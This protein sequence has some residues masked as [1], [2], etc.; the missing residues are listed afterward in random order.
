M[1]RSRR[2]TPPGESRPADD[3]VPATGT[4]ETE[5]GASAMNPTEPERTYAP[6]PDPTLDPVLGP[7]RERVAGSPPP[8]VERE[9]GISP[10]L[11]AALGGV[12]GGIIVAGGG[13]WYL[14]SQPFVP[15]TVSAKLDAL[16]QVR[17]QTQ[18]MAG[19]VGALRSRVDGNASALGGLQDKV[20]GLEKGASGVP[21]RIGGLEQ[22]T[23]E[24]RQQLTGARTTTDTIAGDI[25]G[26]VDEL[27]ARVDALA[28][29]MG[30]VTQASGTLGNAAQQLQSLA[31]TQQRL[32]GQADQLSGGFDQLRKDVQAAEQRVTQVQQGAQQQVA[33]LQNDV[34]GLGARV[35][36]QQQLGAAL[37]GLQQALGAREQ[38]LQE[39]R[40][41]MDQLRQT[42]QLQLGQTQ[43]ATQQQVAQTQQT[44]QQQLAQL[45]QQNAQAVAKAQQQVEARAA[46]VSRAAALSLAAYQLRVA[47]D[48]GGSVQPTADVV[49]RN[50]GDDPALKQVA[51]Q[52]GQ[53]AGQPVPTVAELSQGLDDVARQGTTAASGGAA[54][55]PLAQARSNL[56]GL[57]RLKP[58]AGEGTTAEPS[59][60]TQGVQAARAAL[61]RGDLEAAK[62]AIQPLADGGNQAAKS[63][64]A[65]LGRRQ[66]VAAAADK[67]AASLQTRLASR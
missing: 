56:G 59:A 53:A 10:W 9:R 43:Q 27:R 12:I 62:A 57:I 11:A 8:T 64:L 41:A 32:S 58:S 22:A 1:T 44:V 13:A 48:Q 28:G 7:E 40:Q 42:T 49:R 4:A 21:E 50:A 16:E 35:D 36:Q 25:K 33:G 46:E 65:D 26:R 31:Q 18:T 14:A 61:A 45:Q 30:Q 51:D 2:R 20:A 66:A 47:L 63:W 15:P 23:N 6:E 19:D 67:L 55:D 39:L 29:Q 37:V 54:S 38:Q 3:P 24:L 34:K 52:L 60:G 5:L 17:S